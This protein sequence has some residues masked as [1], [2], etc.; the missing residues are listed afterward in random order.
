MNSPTVKELA[1]IRKSNAETD[2]TYVDMGAISPDEVRERVGSD[3]DSGYNNLSGDAPGPPEAGLMETEHNLGQQGAEADH[4]RNKE[5]AEEA[6]QR[7]LELAEKDTLTNDGWNEADHPRGAGGKFGGGNMSSYLEARKK[8]DELNAA[9]KTAT[10]ELDAA[11]PAGNMGLRSD[12]TKSNPQFQAAKRKVD[13]AFATL[14]NFNKW[15]NQ[16]FAKEAKAY[17]KANP[18]YGRG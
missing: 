9:V 18:G 1:E 13:V 11:F 7:A 5:T 8:Q 2:K 10:Q 16:S 14:Q 17:R 12:E 3:P 4:E 15:V 6:H